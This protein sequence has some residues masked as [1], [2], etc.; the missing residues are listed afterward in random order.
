MTPLWKRRIVKL[1]E[2]GNG[3]TYSEIGE[4]LGLSRT[5]IATKLSEIR[6]EMPDALREE[7]R[8]AAKEFHFDYDAL[9]NGDDGQEENVVV[10]QWMNRSTYDNIYEALDPE[11]EDGEY[12]A[13]EKYQRYDSKFQRGGIKVLVFE[14]GQKRPEREYILRT[15]N[16]IV[17]SVA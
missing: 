17:V 7:D 5:N 9:L 13:F 10:P 16:C 12:L 14:E 6:D 11:I 15:D 1:R 2:S 8:G 4:I 3:F